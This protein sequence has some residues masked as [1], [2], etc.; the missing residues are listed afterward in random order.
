MT[1]I[2]ELGFIQIRKMR[3]TK[4]T[5]PKRMKAISN[6]IQSFLYWAIRFHVPMHIFILSDLR[7]HP[8]LV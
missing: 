2:I 8:P 4:A 1:F 3:G 6:G 7:K 5:I